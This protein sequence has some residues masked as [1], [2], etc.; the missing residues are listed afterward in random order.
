MKSRRGRALLVVALMVGAGCSRRDSS[1]PLDSPLR[2]SVKARQAKA[3][4][5]REISLPADLGCPMDVLSIEDVFNRHDV[6]TALL[7]DQQ[8]VTA[9]D[10]ELGTWYKFRIVSRIWTRKIDTFP[11]ASSDY[12]PR[13]LLPLSPDEVLIGGPDGAV[14]IEG[15]T[16]NSR[17]DG[18]P[19]FRKG[20]TYLLFLMVDRR[21]QTAEIPLKSDGIFKVID[22]RI[23][24]RGDK[25]HPLVAALREMDH[26][27]LAS[28]QKR[29]GWQ[30]IK[31]Q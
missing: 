14:E 21:W 8:S 23:F 16:I 12:R 3:R 2:L 7:M 20:T 30:P 6:V 5:L 10:L 4:G 1:I 18:G 29:L 26:N 27:S 11:P 28:L 17:L 31:Y 22:G 25:S 24:P 15:V 13:K 19:F 9:R